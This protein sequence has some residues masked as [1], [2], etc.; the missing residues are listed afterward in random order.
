MYFLI[1]AYFVL[2]CHMIALKPRRNC[3][4]SR[5]AGIITALNAPIH[6]CI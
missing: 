1:H 6:D 3:K 5:S 4:L 2:T